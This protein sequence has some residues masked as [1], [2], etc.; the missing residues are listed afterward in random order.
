MLSDCTENYAQSIEVEFL[1]CQL[2][3]LKPNKNLKSL[4]S[5]TLLLLLHQKE[6][7]LQKYSGS[8]KI[9]EKYLNRFM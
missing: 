1:A 9:N 5:I 3:I 4:H 2:T 8:Q 7:F 6:Y